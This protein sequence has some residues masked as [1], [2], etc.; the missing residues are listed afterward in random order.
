[1]EKYKGWEINR[2]DYGNYY[3]ATNTKDCDSNMISGK[4]VEIIKEHIDDLESPPKIQFCSDY[5][6]EDMAHL[7]FANKYLT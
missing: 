7:A 2:G 3:E 1:M 4:T 6:Y 5:S